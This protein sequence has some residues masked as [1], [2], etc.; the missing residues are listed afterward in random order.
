MLE[1]GAHL[2]TTE[3]V[4]P[5]QVQF[6]FVHNGTGVIMGASVAVGLGE[7]A[8]S[9]AEVCGELCEDEQYRAVGATLG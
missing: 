7:V 5:F 4:F 6:T 3:W 1:E 8:I 2:Y 9:A